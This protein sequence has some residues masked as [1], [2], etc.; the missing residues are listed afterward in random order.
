MDHMELALAAE[1][2]RIDGEK[3]R[4]RQETER[5][6]QERTRIAAE[7]ARAVAEEGCIAVSKEVVDTVA[8]LTALLDRMEAVEKMRR[9]SQS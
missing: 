4:R 8:T 6:T 9:S 2:L 3:T 7:G 1:R 5:Q